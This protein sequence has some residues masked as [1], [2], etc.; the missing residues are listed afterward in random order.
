V[1]SEPVPADPFELLQSENSEARE[2]ADVLAIDLETPTVLLR[3][4]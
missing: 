4:M 1:P 2:P 3:W